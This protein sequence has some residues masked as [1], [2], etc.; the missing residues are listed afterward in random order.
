MQLDSPL[1]NKHQRLDVPDTRSLAL[2][3]NDFQHQAL[4]SAR[5]HIRLAT[6]DP[7]HSES[8]AINCRLSHCSLNDDPK[9]R[10]VSYCWG[11]DQEQ[12]RSIRVNG[13]TYYV[14]R[15][16]WQLLSHLSLASVPGHVWI[17]ALCI[18]QTNV[19]EKN[20]QV[21]MMSNI[22][23]DA[24]S[25]MVWLGPGDALSNAAV[26]FI[27]RLLRPGLMKGIDD[28]WLHDYGFAA[29]G[30]LLSRD[31]WKRLWIVQELAL[32]SDV[33]V[34]VGDKQVAW[35]SLIDAVNIFTSQ[36]SSIKSAFRS[37][38]QCSGYEDLLENFTHSPAAVLCQSTSDTFLKDGR[39][40]RLAP[41]FSLEALVDKY[42]Y[43][44]CTDARDRVYGLLGLAKSNA[45]PISLS[46]PQELTQLERPPIPQPMKAD[47][48]KSTLSCYSAFTDQCI[49]T[50]GSLDVICRPWAHLRR[51]KWRKGLID[52][53]LRLQVPSWIP[54][55]EEIP[56]TGQGYLR[57]TMRVRG[58][59]FVGKP[60][61]K[62][63]NANNGML[64]HVRF[65]FH[66][67]SGEP[68][69]ALFARG[70]QVATISK[71][72]TRMGD[73]IVH[74]E[75]LRMMVRPP[76]EQNNHCASR[77]NRLWRIPCGNRNAEGQPALSCYGY[78]MRDLLYERDD[79]FAIDT[80]TLLEEYR[81]TGR[82]PH[83][84]QLLE[85]IQSVVWNRRVFTARRPQVSAQSLDQEHEM[86]V[87]IAPMRAK[88]GDK[89]VILYGGSAPMI[90][91]AHREDN[92]TV[93]ELIGDAYVDG[94]MDGEALESLTLDDREAQEKDFEIW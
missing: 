82:E 26:D 61:S 53:D 79:D 60:A 67:R 87:G 48:A 62:P 12:T 86:V 58:D 74:L 41:R 14:N 31:Y 19:F 69:G 80:I 32:A 16:L 30:S 39:G 92:Q 22:F 93:Y 11:L 63:Y 24:T 1:F 76:T 64:A 52:P 40:K 18:D 57:G 25:V 37:N 34:C 6:F 75:A 2:P 91:R 81:D 43:A 27:P 90:L 84:I 44:E 13:K 77:D 23:S 33:Q 55:L 89:V 10:A 15:A 88:E 46:R 85:R 35:Q 94:M 50:S 59:P 65:G 72:S 45:L 70:I 29:L 7:R 5:R 4:D 68:D 9:Y 3:G 36:S 78:A 42:A 8:E 21:A 17:D 47:Y 83:V 66:A 28:S 71:V 56:F 73:G 54:T 49:R 38:P 51:K 20:Q